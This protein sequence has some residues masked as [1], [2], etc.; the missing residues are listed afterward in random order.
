MFEWIVKKFKGDKNMVEKT[1]VAMI[2]EN[3]CKIFKSF[4]VKKQAIKELQDNLVEQM[5]DIL[6]GNQQH[7]NVIL[8]KYGIDGELTVNYDTGGITRK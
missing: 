2:D 7:W 5:A 4:A 1:V 8:E 6:E 3:E